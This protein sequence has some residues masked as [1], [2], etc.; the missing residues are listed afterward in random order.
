MPIA[1]AG[2]SRSG[3][4]KVATELCDKG[5]CAAKKMLYRDVKLHIV[6]Q[7]NH[8]AMP[9]PSFMAISKASQHDLDIAK[10]M[11]D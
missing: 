8:R 4:A 7:C 11:F 1:L 10:E 6:A 2:N 5:Y 9:T 3:R